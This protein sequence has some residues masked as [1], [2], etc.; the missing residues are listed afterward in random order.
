MC[1]YGHSKRKSIVFVLWTSRA[2]YFIGQCC[3]FS[4]FSFYCFLVR[5][6]SFC[7]IFAALF[8]VSK[9]RANNVTD[10]RHVFVTCTVDCNQ[11]YTTKFEKYSH[12][13][14]A[15]AGLQGRPHTRA[16]ARAHTHTLR[17]VQQKMVRYVVRI[18]TMLL[19]CTMRKS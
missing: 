8:E 10:S 1:F 3:C 9:F 16:R 18:R 17:A 7:L 15:S 2:C 13:L 5:N 4:L 11:L 12:S 6:S 14:F 19:C